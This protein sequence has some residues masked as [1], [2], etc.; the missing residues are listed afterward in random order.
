MAGFADLLLRLYLD[1]VLIYVVR[2]RHEPGEGG[3]DATKVNG[4]GMACAEV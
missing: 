4:T 3:L 1:Q 2:G